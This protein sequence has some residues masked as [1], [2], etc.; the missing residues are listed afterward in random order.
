MAELKA[1]E[2]LSCNGNREIHSRLGQGKA[3]ILQALGL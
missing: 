3:I 2:K 1:P